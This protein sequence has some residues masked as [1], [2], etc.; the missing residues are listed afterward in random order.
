MD[1]V[2][3]DGEY[4]RTLTAIRDA[5]MQASP[6]VVSDTLWMP[7]I[8]SETV[9]DFIDQALIKHV[10][11]IEDEKERCALLCDSLATSLEKAADQIEKDG[12]F[13][14]R[15]LWPLGKRVTSIMPKFKTAAASRRAAAQAIRVLSQGCREGWD[16]R[17][18]A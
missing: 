6:N 4:I 10:D 3:K 7:G 16:P 13:T 2:K 1:S 15:A 18:H 5:I 14:T 17:K 9:V 12:S 8:M 11:D